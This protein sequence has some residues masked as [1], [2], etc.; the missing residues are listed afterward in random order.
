MTVHK[1]T[2]FGGMILALCLSVLH[3][4]EPANQTYALLNGQ[5]FNGQTFKTKTFYVVNGIF[6]E[7]KPARVD[8]TVDLKNGFVIPPFGDAHCHH[9]MS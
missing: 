9:L 6:T 5:W 2:F 1:T 3:A 7:R 8:E 4:Q